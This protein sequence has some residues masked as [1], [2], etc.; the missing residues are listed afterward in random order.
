MFYEL[1]Y[2]AQFY[3]EIINYMD[4]AS[5]ESGG[6]TNA[7]SSVVLYSKFDAHKLARVVG[8]QRCQQMLASQ[9]TVHMFVTGDEN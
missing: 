3:S 7:T 6:E 2:F 5:L 1:P 4:T 9:Q 8:S